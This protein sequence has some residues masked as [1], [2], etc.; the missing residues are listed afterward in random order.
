MEQ[1][2]FIDRFFHSQ[3]ELLDFTK[4]ENRDA[5][6]LYTFL[7]NMHTTADRLKED[8]DC[9][10]KSS[11]DFKI[12][13][14]IRNYFHHVGDVDE[15]RLNVVVEPG[16]MVS[17]QEHLLIPL[18]T[19]AK[20]VKSFIDK[21]TLPEG[22]KNHK[23]KQDFVVNEI[24]AI[25]EIFDYTQDLL[26]NMEAMCNKP[27]LKL[28]GVV[29]E[30]GFDMYKSVYNVTNIIAD[31]CRSIEALKNKSVIVNLGSSYTAANNIGKHDVF[32]HPNQVPI[33]TTEGFIY[34]K[35]IEAAI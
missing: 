6:S 4:I 15:V 14:L 8:F 22:H 34:P 16:V 20:S 18:E 7:N 26:Q 5:N 17:H 1:T 25:S 33:T 27:S 2:K 9:D 31:K 21:N 32:C 35:S 11:P 3:Y 30:L 10:I 29:Y 12:L 28:D 13:R 19:F 23:K 24:N